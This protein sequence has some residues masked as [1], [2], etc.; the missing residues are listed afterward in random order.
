M[1]KNNL[2]CYICFFTRYLWLKNYLRMFVRSF[3]NTFQQS[4]ILY[5]TILFHLKML[6]IELKAVLLVGALLTLGSVHRVESTRIIKKFKCWTSYIQSNICNQ[7]W[8]YT[9]VEPL[10]SNCKLLALPENIRLGWK[11]MAVANT[12]TYY[13]KQQFELK[14]FL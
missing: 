11:W 14:I 3:L 1:N 2:K 4:L 7:E 9:R 10:H 5:M 12:L 6:I 8:I 13:N